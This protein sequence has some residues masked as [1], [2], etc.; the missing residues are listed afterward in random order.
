M[1][2]A[3]IRHVQVTIA[4]V[5]GGVRNDPQGCAVALAI[6]R[7]LGS[8]AV[9]TGAFIDVGPDSIYRVTS[10]LADWIFSFDQGAPVAPIVVDL[11]AGWAD[12]G[13]RAHG[14]PIQARQDRG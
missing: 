9:V 14:Q 2:A 6:G 3:G 10:S 7:E 1:I 5:E 13:D 11:L 8:R 4:D 12:I